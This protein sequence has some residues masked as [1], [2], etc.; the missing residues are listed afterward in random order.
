MLLC[1]VVRVR[2]ITGSSPR[3]SSGHLRTLA[4]AGFM[5][6]HHE[7]VGH[8]HRREDGG[9][10]R[11]PLPG[12]NV[13]IG[14]KTA[15][16]A[17]TRAQVGHELSHPL[18]RCVDGEAHIGLRVSIRNASK[19]EQVISRGL[20]TR[21]QL[22]LLCLAGFERAK[23]EYSPPGNACTHFQLAQP[24]FRCA[25]HRAT[26]GGTT[27]EVSWACAL[28]RASSAS[29]CLSGPARSAGVLGCAIRRGGSCPP[30]T[31]LRWQSNQP[32]CDPI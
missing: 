9:D 23:D 32:S 18:A 22:A 19:N 20:A 2:V 8:V 30:L 28:C 13:Y 24:G 5:P 7:P 12:T 31:P 26:P 27:E 25:A 6:R 1:P 3:L 16:E 21:D 4:K 14:P 11:Q 10:T 17:V 29:Q 15:Q